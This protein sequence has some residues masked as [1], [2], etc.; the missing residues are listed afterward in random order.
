[1]TVTAGYLRMLLREQAGPVSD[2]Q[3]KMLEEAERS[4]TRISAL[5]SEMSELGKLEAG[6]VTLPTVTF[7]LASLATDVASNMHEGED[8]GIRL[9]VRATQPINVAGDRPRLGSALRALVQAA[10]RERAEPG[11][12]VVQCSMI[13][14]GS[15]PWAVVAIGDETVTPAL[16]DAAR[17]DSPPP[18]DEWR[19][20]MG[21][22]LPVGRRLIEAH[23]GG[24]WSAPS[25]P[26]AGS[27]LRLPITKET[28]VRSQE[29]GDRMTPDS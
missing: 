12:V 4:C 28:G 26:R 22:A 10:L 9:D 14:E 20:G 25:S 7:D 27:A 5:I 17:A 15:K 8:R 13:A 18:F 3:R 23:G 16:I 11:V 1:M 29:S 24:V 19:G 6:E 2:R 21:L